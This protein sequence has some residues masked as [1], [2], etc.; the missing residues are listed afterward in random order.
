M[1]VLR[2]VF[3]NY[4]NFTG[5]KTNAKIVVFESDD[6]GSIRVPSHSVYSKLKKLDIPVDTFHYD[7]LDCLESE[8]DLLSLFDGLFIV[9]DSQSKPAR[10][11]FNT[12]VANPDFEQIRKDN[13]SRYSYQSFDDTYK[14]YCGKSL[15]PLWKEAIANECMLPQF[16]GREHVN[17]SLWMQLLASNNK[18]VRKG[19]DLSYL[20]YTGSTGYP[21][22]KHFLSAFH[23]LNSNDLENKR[24]VF[25][26]GLKLFKNLFGFSPAS[27]IACNYT[28]PSAMEKEFSKEG[29]KLLQGQR[30]HFDPGENGEIKIRRHYTG[31]KNNWGQT[32][33]VRNCFFEPA[34]NPA[35][36]WVSSCL[37]EISNAFFWNTPAIISSHRVNFIGSLVE[38][39]RTENIKS[40]K[41]LLQKIVKKWPDVQFLTTHELE[42]YTRHS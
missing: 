29:I 2:S 37:K 24:I 30:A 12:I 16:H 25:S 42:K 15:L 3:S 33:L 19:F 35:K 18:Q 27:F 40:L 31:Q 11:T 5:L 21:N 39:N 20:G 13:F 22:H 28:W 23:I 4:S 9:K 34:A 14:Q 17:V 38:K 26:D 32:F 41:K 7:A 10:F 6:W 8:N 1:N 36:D